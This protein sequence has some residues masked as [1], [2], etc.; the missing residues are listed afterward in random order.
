MGAWRPVKKDASRK[1][2][3]NRISAVRG[4]QPLLCRRA[5]VA[6]V[7]RA[8]F[9][10]DFVFCRGPIRSGFGVPL[11]SICTLLP[12]P[13]ARQ[14]LSDTRNSIE[15]RQAWLCCLCSLWSCCR[16]HAARGQLRYW[17]VKELKIA[18]HEGPL[19]EVDRQPSPK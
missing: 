18:R 15:K 11:C 13:R 8:S 6:C 9:E 10:L 16:P 12:M 5:L 4:L 14:M 17:Q 19:G 3:I 7:S 1:F 2:E